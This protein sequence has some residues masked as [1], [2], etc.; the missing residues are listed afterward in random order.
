[1]FSYIKT[2]LQYVGGWKKSP[3]WCDIIFKLTNEIN[4]C[5]EEGSLWLISSK[6]LGLLTT[7]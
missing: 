3:I 2:D 5:G 1:M 7:M 4:S 6:E